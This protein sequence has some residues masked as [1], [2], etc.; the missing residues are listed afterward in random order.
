VIKEENPVVGE[1]QI[2]FLTYKKLQPKPPGG[3]LSGWERY[4]LPKTVK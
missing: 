4:H 2:K 1:K 3:K